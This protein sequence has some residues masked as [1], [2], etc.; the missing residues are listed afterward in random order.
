MPEAFNYEKNRENQL[1]WENSKSKYPNHQPPL[2]SLQ[3]YTHRLFDF[4]FEF[5]FLDGTFPEFGGVVARKDFFAPSMEISL[6][7]DQL[8]LV[9]RHM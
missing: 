1:D 6:R 4:C 3:R 9:F 8:T 7:I 5:V 2:S